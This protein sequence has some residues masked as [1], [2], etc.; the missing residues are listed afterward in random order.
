MK[1]LRLLL[2]LPLIAAL[3]ACGGGKGSPAPAPTNFSMTAQ[4]S[5][6]YM[7]WDAVPGVEYWVFCDPNQPTI[8]SHSSS[9]HPSRI[10]YRGVYASGNQATF[11]ANQ[12][13]GL[14]NGT[15][16]ACTV[17]GRYN[18]GEGGPDATPQTG[19]PGYSGTWFS[20]ATPSPVWSGMTLKS[21]AYGL[22]TG[23]GLSTD[24]FVGVGSGGQLVVSTALDADAKVTWTVPQQPLTAVSGDLSAVT[25]YKNGNRFVAVGL[26]GKVVY[27]TSIAS[28]VQ[29]G[30][31]S[32]APGQSVNAL[33]SGSTSLVAV[34]DAG[35][36][37]TSGD[38]VSWST[39]DAT[40]PASASLK[41]VAWAAS[42]NGSATSP[43]WIAVGS[44]GT[45]LKSTDN[46]QNWAAAS[47]GTTQT[48]RSVAVLPVTNTINNIT[49]YMLVAV[50]D[51]GTV[52][53]SS[54]DGA[55]WQIPTSISP[56]PA[57]FVSVTAGTGRFMAVDSTGQAFT[58]TSGSPLVWSGGGSGLSQPATVV[59]YIPS[60]TAF[61]NGWMVFDAAGNQRIAK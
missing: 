25:F 19:T 4:E 40:V 41:S 5:Q 55:S 51:A 21:V 47:S 26:D 36:I 28:W 60:V 16:Y 34:G 13:A 45:I 35:L 3:A 58:S 8:D 43:Y 39:S 59:R 49:N 54:D 53:V 37:R 61:S 22:P 15:P 57:N 10:Y 17:N 42:A 56:T 11:Y 7:T 20:G 9:L 27:A 31:I 23:L 46:G 52:L 1:Y 44:G 18:N 12:L 48:L 29:G 14:A 6:F 32:L 30:T 38:G 24:Q 2:P 33:A 50:G